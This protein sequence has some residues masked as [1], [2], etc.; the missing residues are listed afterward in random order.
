MLKK[1][2]AVAIVAS[3]ATVAFAETV[4]APTPA[5]KPAVEQKADAPKLVDTPKAASMKSTSTVAKRHKHRH[6]AKK[7]ASA[8]PA[9]APAK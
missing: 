1:F 2:A 5:A 8:K 4:P 9:V 6:Q 7:L 3:F